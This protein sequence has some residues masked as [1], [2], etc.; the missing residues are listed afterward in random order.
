ISDCFTIRLVIP[1]NFLFFSMISTFSG[2]IS[3]AV[4]S[5]ATLARDK[6]KEPEPPPASTVLK[7]PLTPVL[8]KIQPMSLGSI[9]CGPRCKDSHKS[10]K[11]GFKAKK[12]LFLL[13]LI[14]LILEIKSFLEIVPVDV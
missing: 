1:N 13:D 12:D 4:T 11:R 10:G 8:A 6:H 7:F 3:Y 5:L 2:L 14:L 9:T